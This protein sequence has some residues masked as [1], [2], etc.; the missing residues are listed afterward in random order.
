MPTVMQ[1][2]IVLDLHLSPTG[3][4]GKIN[5]G[6]SMAVVGLKETKG[7]PSKL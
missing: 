5:V 4:L 7:R 1:I 2:K 3:T 6:D